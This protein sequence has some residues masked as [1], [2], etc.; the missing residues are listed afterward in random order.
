MIASVGFIS[1]SGSGDKIN[2]SAATEFFVNNGSS[3]SFIFTGRIMG[4]TK[5]SC[6]FLKGS[7][8][9]KASIPPSDILNMK[10]YSNPCSE[11]ALPLISIFQEI[12]VF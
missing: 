11:S 5:I 2:I 1:A 3:T 9:G 12:F 8:S 6:G 10:Q 7:T 4:I